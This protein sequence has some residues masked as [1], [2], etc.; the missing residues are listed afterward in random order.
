MRSTQ[1]VE[2]A[3]HLIKRLGNGKGTLA[4]L[5]RDIDKKVRAERQTRAHLAYQREVLITAKDT[6]EA[7]LY[8]TDI[9]EEN[10]R[11]LG[12]FGQFEMVKEMAS[13]F[14]Y[15]SKPQMVRMATKGCSKLFFF[16]PHKLVKLLMQGLLD[17]WNHYSTSMP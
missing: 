7:Y 1:R 8:F 6:S 12:D 9:Q 16:F 17:R 2:K 10:R 13:S 15:R 3:H 5:V 11:Y 4:Q 14:Y